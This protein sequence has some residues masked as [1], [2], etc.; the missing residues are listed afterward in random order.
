MWEG[1]FNRGTTVI[2]LLLQCVCVC[3]C[4]CMCVCVCR[5]AKL[6]SIV[7]GGIVI[8]EEIKVGYWVHAHNTHTL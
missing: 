4:V 2:K 1:S 7:E 5:G 6:E 3:V 8:D